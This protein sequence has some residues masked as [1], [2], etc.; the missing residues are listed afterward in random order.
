MYYGMS[1]HLFQFKWS[2]RGRLIDRRR[3]KER[4]VYTHDC[5]KLNKTNM[6]PEKI[7]IGFLSNKILTPSIDTSRLA[8]VLIHIA[9]PLITASMSEPS[10]RVIVLS[11]LASPF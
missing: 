2:K 1:G 5:S 3:F 6:L 9:L 10:F 8:L 4:G 11:L 7:S